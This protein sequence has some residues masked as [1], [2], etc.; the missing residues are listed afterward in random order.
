M[1]TLYSEKAHIDPDCE[2]RFGPSSFDD[3]V[4]ATKYTWFA[5]NGIVARG[6]EVPA[7]ALPQMIVVAAKQGALTPSMLS[8]T[9]AELA[10][11]LKQQV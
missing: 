9:I 4:M 8:E 2:V 3:S 5:G 1:Q 11:V 10:T 7:I 6:G